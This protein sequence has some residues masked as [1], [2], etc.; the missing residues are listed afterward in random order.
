MQGGTSGGARISVVVPTHHRPDPL[1]RLLRSL[2]AQTYPHAL[3]EIVVV[4]SPADP[5]ALAVAAA[6]GVSDVAMRYATLPE[7]RWQG[8]NPAAKRNHGVA[9]ASGEWIA[10][11]DD[12]CVASPTWLAAAA[13]RFGEAGIGGLEGR[14]AIPAVVPPTATY[15]GLLLMTRPNG[16]QTCNMLYRRADFQRLGGFDTAFPFY[17]EDTDLAW[18]FLDAG[19]RL[20]FAPDVVIEHPVP[21]AAPWRLWADAKR[22]VLLPYL[23]RKHPA[24]YRRSRIRPLRRSSYAYLATEAALLIAVALGLAGAARFVAVTLAALVAGHLFKLFRG[25]RVGVEELLVTALLLPVTPPIALWQF[26][27]GCLRERVWPGLR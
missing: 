24:E 20:P 18:T 27:R 15:R 16:F 17:L 1:A 12:D 10:F 11:T 14:K 8:R 21:P 9:L 6:A 22:P 19:L 4:G 13:A 25:C 26:L 7:D 23:F 3:F 2:A 5:G